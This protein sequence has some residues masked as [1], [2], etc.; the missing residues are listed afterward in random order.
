M[1]DDWS[2]RAAALQRQGEHL[3]SAGAWHS[4]TRLSFCVS[5]L[6]RSQVRQNGCRY[7]RVFLWLCA[8][9][10]S[11][12]TKVYYGL[13]TM[14]CSLVFLSPPSLCTHRFHLFKMFFRLMVSVLNLITHPVWFLQQKPIFIY[15]VVSKRSSLPER[16]LAEPRFWGMNR[17]EAGPVHLEFLMDSWVG[18]RRS[19]GAVWQHS[20]YPSFGCKMK[21]LDIWEMLIHLKDVTSILSA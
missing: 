2:S 10:S 21:H 17:H 1:R 14:W 15:C 9:T 13:V 7:Y 5:I 16:L 12:E 11:S 4:L 18:H 6:T 8:Y 20:I 19:L 3:S